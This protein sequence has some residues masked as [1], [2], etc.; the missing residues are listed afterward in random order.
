MTKDGLEYISNFIQSMVCDENIIRIIKQNYTL[1]LDRYDFDAISLPDNTEGFYCEYSG[2]KMIKAYEPFLDIIKTMIH[3]YGTDVEALLDEA[4]IYSLQKSIFKSYIETGIVKREEDSILGERD[5]EKGKM[6]KGIVNLL[7]KISETNNMFLLLN[8]AHQMC[9]STLEIISELQTRTSYSLKILIITNEMGSVKGY[10]SRRYNEFIRNCD[11]LG[12]VLEW[13]FEEEYGDRNSENAFV[14]QNT[15]EELIKIRN[16]FF[17]FA[18]DQA[19]YYM[20]MIYQKVELDKVKVSVEYRINMFNLYIVI[21]IYKEDYSSALILCE[22][23]KRI[24]AHDMEYMKNYKYYYYKSMASMYTCNEEDAKKNAELCCCTALKLDNEYLLFKAMLLKNMSELI[25][26]KDI[27]ICDKDIEV[28]EELIHLCYKYNYINHLA[29]IFVYD[30]DNDF[31]LYATAEGVE[32]RTTYVTK[33]IRL[34]EQI[35]NEQFLVEAYRKS[36]M[37]ASCNGFFATANHFYMKSIEVVKKNKN[38]FEEANIY[39][40]LGYNCCSVDKYSEANRYYNKALEIFYEEKSTDYILETLYNMGI[41]AILA[42]DYPHASEYLMTVH[43]ILRML[44]KNSLRVSNIS[45]IFGLIALAAFKQGNYYT[46]QLYTN[47]SKHFLSY[48]LDCKIEEF[49]NYLWS[50]DLFLYFYVSALIA[51]RNGKYEESLADFDNAEEHMKRSGGSMFFN[52]VHF[53]VDKSK[54]LRKIGRYTESVELLKEAR[55]YFNLKGN[56]L[57]VRMFDE[58]ISTG[59]WEYPAV[60]M[61]LTGVTI[62]RIMDYIRLESIDNEAKSKRQQLRFFGTFQEL[63]GHQ[64]P[65]V[66]NETK[67]LITN[68]KSNFNLDNLLFISYENEVPEIKFNDFEYEISDEEINIIVEYFKNNTA[69]FALSKFSNNY[70]DYEQILKIF[71]RSK[72]FSIIAAPIYRSEKLYS[73]FITLVKIPESWNSVIDREVL[74]EDDLEMYMLVFRQIIDA[75]E[76]YRLNEQL[77]LQAVTDELTGLYNRKGYYEKIDNLIKEAEETGEK[78]NAAIMYMDLDHFKYFNDTFGHNAGDAL[79]EKFADIFRKS[80]GEYG[81]VVRFGGD[82]FLIL[83]Y[84][85]DDEIIDGISRKIYE[86]I[87]KE[88]GFTGL[89]CRDSKNK[90]DIPAEYR[91]TCSIGIEIGVGMSN[92]EDFTELQKHADIALY[93]GKNNGRGKAVRY[94]EIAAQN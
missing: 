63:V 62:D 89:V 31:R 60:T 65:S 42:G 15:D 35:D 29:H 27:W 79:L 37:V 19:D 53:A 69:G 13:P 54:L 22:S 78:I 82:E 11:V 33:G 46:A 2:T 8:D 5:Y 39:N 41:N 24:N 10:M 45:K 84:S 52:Y 16:M 9:D 6:I 23:L 44:K 87:D 20:N 93:Y 91:T 17:T 56:F 34:A 85:A 75:I 1:K 32:E 61:S 67:T 3:K 49:H 28:T 55:V 57:N 58:L 66:E 86:L 30:F 21:N 71:D 72:V 51:D 38:R 88:K 50:D 90:V 48:I 12:M 76:K 68:F 74:D 83:L 7:L 14:L 92:V 36:V 18:I 25:G 80:C 47:K 70:H 94:S 4:G 40:G 73:I 77:K 81:D 43:N 26:W 59:K 64:Y